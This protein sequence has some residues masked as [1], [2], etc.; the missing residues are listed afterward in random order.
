MCLEAIGCVVTSAATSEAALAAV[1]RTAFEVAFLDLRLGTQDG[2][3]LLPRLHAARPAMAIVVITA[4]A[5]IDTAVE[6]IKLGAIEYLPK[7]FTP[8]QIRNVVE[9][10]AARRATEARIADLE[11]L[12]AEELPGI[13]IATTSPRMLSVL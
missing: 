2:M 9:Q 3:A 13:D 1:E 8:A 6:A 10:I 12:V 4:H 5:T 11:A 7:P